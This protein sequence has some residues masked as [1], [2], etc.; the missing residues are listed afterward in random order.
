MVQDDIRWPEHGLD[1]PVLVEKIRNA[2]ENQEE[3][4]DVQIRPAMGKATCQQQMD[5]DSKKVHLSNS[6]EEGTLRP[7][8]Q[9]DIANIFKAHTG[10]DDFK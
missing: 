3:L 2:A 5:K 1:K 4:P 7:W 8:T 10:N 9:A 6:N